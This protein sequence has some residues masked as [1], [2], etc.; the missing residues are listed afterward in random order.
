MT[1][2]VY[3]P[4][5]YV[6]LSYRISFATTHIELM[7]HHN[8]YAAAGGVLYLHFIQLQYMYTKHL[9]CIVHMGS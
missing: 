9:Y 6:M 3:P 4:C 1:V 2:T 8:R 5:N 7:M